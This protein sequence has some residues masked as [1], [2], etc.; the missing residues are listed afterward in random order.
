[1]DPQLYGKLIFNKV[2]KNIQWK[3]R[4]CLQ[5][6]VLEKLYSY[7]QKNETGPFPYTTHK[8]RLKMGKR[9]KCETGI[10]QHLRGEHRQQPLLPWLQQLLAGHIYKGK[11][12]KAK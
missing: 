2:G 12:N 11:G 1:M 4:Q 8:N 9:P 5:K 7:M 6:M 3:K 10:R